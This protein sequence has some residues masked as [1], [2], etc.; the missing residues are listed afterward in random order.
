M[1][2]LLTNTVVC[3]SG[4]QHAL[5]EVM[6]MTTIKRQG[7]KLSQIASTERWAPLLLCVTAHLQCMRLICQQFWWLRPAQWT[8]YALSFSTCCFLPNV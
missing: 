5:V 7:A 8:P 4:V 6:K 1:I 3:H 2:F